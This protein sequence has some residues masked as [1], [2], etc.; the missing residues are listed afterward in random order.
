ML[1]YTRPMN[2]VMKTFLVW[3][4]LLALPLQGYAA[5][6]MLT[7]S[8]DA[9]RL[10]T[11]VA[12]E[13]QH[14][15]AAHVHAEHANDQQTS[16]DPSHDKHDK[17]CNAPCNAC[18]VCCLGAMLMSSNDWLSGQ[19]ATDLPSAAPAEMFTGHIPGALE[20][21]PRFFLV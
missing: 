13:H 8:M 6:T 10:V 21:P 4:L 12:A 2:R 11:D 5:A 3:L 9:H 15:G 1:C 14:A 20:R 16:H 7:C 17:R 18:Q 19:M